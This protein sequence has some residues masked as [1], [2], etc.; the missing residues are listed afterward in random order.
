MQIKKLIEQRD[1]C[2]SV[3][4]KSDLTLEIAF[5]Y[6]EAGDHSSALKEYQKNLD[7][8]RSK[9]DRIQCAVGHRL[10]ADCCI[11][12]GEFDQAIKHTNEYL[13]LSVETNNKL[14]QQR[15]FVTLGRCFLNR[16]EH[17]KDGADVLKAHKS[18]SQAFLNSIKLI[19]ELDSG[20][21]AEQLGEMRAVS[22]LNLGQVLRSIGDHRSSNERFLQCISLARKYHLPKLLFRASYQVTDLILCTY[23]DKYCGPCSKS[24]LLEQRKSSSL[25]HALDIVGLALRS[26]ISKTCSDSESKELLKTLKETYAAIHLSLGNFRKA[27][28]VYR[29]LKLHSPSS[30]NTC[31]MMIKK[32]MLLSKELQSLPDHV[33]ESVDE[34]L[35]AARKHEHL[36]D[37]FSQLELNGLA[38]NHYQFMLTHAESA[39]HLGVSTNSTDTST[40]TKLMDAALVSVAE[41][42]RALNDYSQCVQTYKR[43]IQWVTSTGLPTTELASSWF[44]MAQAQRLCF[45]SGGSSIAPS[46]SL[47]G[48][49]AVLEM[50]K[51]ALQASKQSDT[52]R[53]TLEI[54]TE[55]EDYYI[56]HD[57]PEEAAF[58]R[59]EIA[60]YKQSRRPHPEEETE[61]EDEEEEDQ[62]AGKDTVD[63]SDPDEDV[64]TQYI[65]SLSS[66][67]EIDRCIGHAESIDEFRSGKRG[68]RKGK[69]L[70]LKTN[71]KGE[72]PLH[73]AS[74]NGD[75]DHVVKLIEI[76]G[77][78]VNVADGAG[79][80]PI[81]EA[82]FH[83]RTEVAIYLLDRGARLDDTGCPSDVSTPLFEAIHNGSLATALVLVKRGANLWHRNKQGECLPELLDMWQPKRRSAMSF[84]DQRL[85]FDELLTAIRSRLGA[86]QHPVPDKVN[87]ITSS[88]FFKSLLES[89][90]N[91]QVVDLQHLALGEDDC[92]IV[93]DQLFLH[94]VRTV[95][96]LNLQGNGIT[97]STPECRSSLISAITRMATRLTALDLSSNAITMRGLLQFLNE[98]TSDLNP[99]EILSPSSPLPRLQIL[100]LAHN[101]FIGAGGMKSDTEELVEDVAFISL[102]GRLITYFPKL[103]HL[104]LTGCW[105]GLSP[106]PRTSSVLT[107]AC[108][109]SHLSELNLDWNPHLSTEDISTL[110]ESS[111]LAGLRSL[112]LRGCSMPETEHG[113]PTTLPLSPTQVASFRWTTP[114][115]KRSAPTFPRSVPSRGDRLLNA[116]S[117]LMSKGHFHLQTLDLGNCQ[118]SHHC[119][120]GLRC[121]FGTLG[122]SL[123]TVQLDRNPGLAECDPVASNVWCEVLR[124]TA[125][126]ASALVSLSIDLPAVRLHRR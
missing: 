31:R 102:I 56:C 83:D 111:A 22:L 5:H 114:L 16:A 118:L 104:N 116:L 99:G 52:P 86:N 25:R 125:L 93:L 41:T 18:A 77:H 65:D 37:I 120:D 92:G 62:S 11:E 75:L 119:L 10:I 27:S 69:A 90:R 19:G 108:S 106:A 32:S 123:T 29:L 84:N 40:L 74:I 46:S 49:D 38:L 76:L 88:R 109:V 63:E 54:L 70:C 34:H 33:P 51:H 4:T 91:S 78:P 44:S 50:L 64:V 82:A 48:S 57:Q 23:R 21:S 35:L 71:M 1:R 14:E 36:G 59:R 43:E 126:S 100:S 115:P 9:D 98:L 55:L 85:L 122:T 103:S 72:T 28:K 95:S 110:L 20:L 87:L 113:Y 124:A 80:L 79:W 13:K 96:R 61:G 8:W 6:T 47:T 26:P 15:A 66:D 105:L 42:F 58:V 89:T 53:L 3:S 112:T 7:L 67:S 30:S 45:P 2:T 12:L 81:H 60:E 24:S 107:S 121:L 101:P 117:T 17:L 68:D 73:V 97:L 94:G 39:Y